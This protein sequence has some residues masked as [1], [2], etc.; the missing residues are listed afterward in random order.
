MKRNFT[1]PFFLLFHPAT[2]ELPNPMALHHRHIAPPLFLPPLPLT[3]E[4]SFPAVMTSF[5][6]PDNNHNNKNN[7]RRLRPRRRRQWRQPTIP[8]TAGSKRRRFSG[9]RE[10]I[11]YEPVVYEEVA[12]YD[13]TT[14][15]SL[16]VLYCPHWPHL[17]FT[18]TPSSFATYPIRATNSILSTCTHYPVNGK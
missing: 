2:H 13:I 3:L 12:W 11:H 15:D 4:P 7:Q 8:S 5:H 16:E 14:P 18:P 9:D 17:P 10:N 1:S 6:N